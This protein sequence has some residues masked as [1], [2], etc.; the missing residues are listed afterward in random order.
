[1]ISLLRLLSLS[2]AEQGQGA[3]PVGRALHGGARGV[4]PGQ[5]LQGPPVSAGDGPGPAGG[6][7]DGEGR[8]RR[9]AVDRLPAGRDGVAALSSLLSGQKRGLW[10]LQGPICFKRQPADVF[11]LLKMN[12][13]LKFTTRGALTAGKLSF[14]TRPEA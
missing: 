1:M 9:P 11:E 5:D 3:S 8:G 10:D 4:Q 13:V 7:Q 2:P 6:H 12:A 14:P